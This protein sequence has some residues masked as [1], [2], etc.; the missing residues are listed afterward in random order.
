MELPVIDKSLA[1]LGGACAVLLGASYAFIG[2]TYPFLSL[3]ERVVGVGAA[4]SY[5]PA[6]LQN[7]SPAIVLYWLTAIG[8]VLGIAAV[9][10]ISALVRRE[11]LGW[12]DWTSYMA[13]FGFVVKALD[14]FRGLT[15]IQLR[16]ET[17]M[18]S[19]DSTR[20][21]I[22]ATR[23]T[24]DYHGW[25]AFGAVG[26]W[27]LVVCLLMLRTGRYPKLISWIGLVVAF[28]YLVGTAGFV[29][30]NVTLLSI[31][32]VLIAIAGPFWYGWMGYTLWRAGQ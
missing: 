32:V 30:T 29:V 28:G 5:Y 10:A 19:D 13:T 1:K 4:S 9:Q 26:L 2:I 22:G 20:L 7:P 14:S 11:N 31:G 24:L 15:L 3:G 18:N 23:L 25:F 12:V 16:A 21:A 6:F 27:V 17:W 8:G